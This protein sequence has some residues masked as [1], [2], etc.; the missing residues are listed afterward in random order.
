MPRKLCFIKHGFLQNNHLRD[1][2]DSL[3]SC[4]WWRRARGSH[5]GTEC[6][7]SEAFTWY[8]KM[9][10][11]SQIVRSSSLFNKN[12]Y[13]SRKW[14]FL[15]SEFFYKMLITSFS[16]FVD[17]KWA[18]ITCSDVRFYVFTA[19]GMR[20]II[21]WDLASCLRFR[22]LYYGGSKYLWNVYLTKRR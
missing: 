9:F 10:S 22:G 21:F 3:K 12:F 15:S 8:H 14:W 17:I 5:T 4:T 20:I 11:V 2:C 18:E 6:S 1:I 13:L 16:V 19:A 7:S